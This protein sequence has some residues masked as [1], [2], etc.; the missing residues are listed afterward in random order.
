MKEG[1]PAGSAPS[2]VVLRAALY[3][4]TVGAESLLGELVYVHETRNLE[5][6]LRNAPQHMEALNKSLRFANGLLRGERHEI[7]TVLVLSTSHVKRETMELIES[8]GADTAT[9]VSRYGAFKH[10]PSAHYEQDCLEDE[11]EELRAIYAYCREHGFEWF[12][13]DA[14]GPCI[15]AL[16]TYEWR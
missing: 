14:D 7:I 4:V 2:A 6:S 11:P 12:R 3:D 16:P 9:A 15:E 8:E 5:D 1:Q 10:V 13:L